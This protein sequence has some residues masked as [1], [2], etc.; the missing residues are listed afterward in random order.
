[1][2]FLILPVAMLFATPTFAN[3]GTSQSVCESKCSVVHFNDEAAEAGCKSK[4]I[5]QRAA[6]STEQGAKD[7]I[8]IGKKGAD[9]VVETGQ[10]AWENTKSFIRGATE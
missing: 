1:M 10:K 2:R 9:A 3:C 5:A 6:C 4:C 8:E 7:A